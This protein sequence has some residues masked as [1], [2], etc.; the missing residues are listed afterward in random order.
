MR[1]VR[2]QRARRTRDD[3]ATSMF[4]NAEQAVTVFALPSAEE[5]GAPMTDPKVDLVG[6]AVANA[7][8]VAG[9]AGAPGAWALFRN[10]Q[11]LLVSWW[12]ARSFY[13]AVR[14]V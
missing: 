4:P 13:A 11:S 7:V 8:A 12:F 1:N 5:I 14:L 9:R 3:A 6:G 2:T 10:P